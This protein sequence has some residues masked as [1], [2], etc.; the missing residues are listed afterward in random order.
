[1]GFAD[2]IEFAF[3]VRG[4]KQHALLVYDLVTGGHRCKQETS[5][6]QR[7]VMINE[8]IAEEALHRRPYHH[9]I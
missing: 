6:K 2:E 3:K 9:C 7:G 4:H 5:K 1:M 8:I